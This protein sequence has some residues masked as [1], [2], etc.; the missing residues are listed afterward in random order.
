MTIGTIF[1][2]FIVP[3]LYMLIAK[4]HHEK[5]LMD[6]DLEGTEDV[7]VTSELEPALARDGNGNG[8]KQ[9]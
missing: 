6:P 1:T 4:E 3:S 8:W 7:D 5:S 9:A 2:L